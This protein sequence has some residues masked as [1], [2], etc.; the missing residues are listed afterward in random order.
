MK[1][2]PAV[3]LRLG[4]SFAAIIIPILLLNKGIYGS[5]IFTFSIPM[6]WQIGF[7]GKSID[8][9]GF[10]INSFKFSIITGIVSG[11]LLGFFGGSILTYL[12]IR[13]HVYNNVHK[14]QLTMGIFNISFPLQKEI[15]YRLL[16]ISNSTIGVCAYL[17]FC[18]FVIGLGE[19][20]FWRGFIQKKLSSYFSSNKSVWITAILFSLIHF[21]I[22]TILPVKTGISFLTLITIVGGIWGY[23]FKYFDN[24]WPSAIS[25]GIVAFI[26]WKY[27]FFNP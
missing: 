6:L 27:Y 3:I 15:G 1:I 5:F 13:G 11:C 26:I 25:H 2:S 7:L 9:L 23:L 12:G 16:S 4:I 19:E 17:I 14:L 21:Y 20:I 22:F 10:R 24:V 18:I 8:T